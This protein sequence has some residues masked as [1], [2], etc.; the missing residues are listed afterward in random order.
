MWRKMF[1]EREREQGGGA[2]MKELFWRANYVQRNNICFKLGQLYGKSIFHIFPQV[3]QVLAFKLTPFSLAATFFLPSTETPSQCF[4]VRDVRHVCLTQS[5][6]LQSGLMS[7]SCQCQRAC[8]C[9]IHYVNRINP[10]MWISKSS[11]TC[12]IGLLLLSQNYLCL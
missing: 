6:L 9:L 3:L 1:V 2:K 4:L 8:F 7:F 10:P 5:W 11:S 12:T